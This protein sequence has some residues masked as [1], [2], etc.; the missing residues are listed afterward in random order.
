[1]TH[2]QD[3]R[4]ALA[5]ESLPAA[6]HDAS[7]AL[8]D[9]VQQAARDNT[10][11]RLVGGDSKG[12]Y[13]RPVSGE[14]LSL[15]E[16]TGIVH[17]D[18]VELVVTVRAGTRLTDLQQTLAEAGQ[19]LAFEPPHFADTATVGGMVACGIA[20]PRRPWAGSVRDF[21]LGTR[22]ITHDAKRLRFGG[23]VMKNVAGYDLSRLM[24]GAQ[25]T[26]GVIDEVSFKVLPRPAAS[27][28]LR[29]EMTRDAAMARL[30][31][32]GR[33]PL[34]I[35]G[36]AHDGETLHIRLEGGAGS[37]A[38]TRERLGGEPD[39]TDFWR[40]LRELKLDFF[41]RR[42][43]SRPLW[44]LSLPHRAPA[45]PLDGDE[46]VDWAGAQRWWRSH[47]SAET[48]RQHAA[49][50]GGHATRI[51]LDQPHGIEMPFTPLSPVL[52][53]YHR[54]LKAELDPHGI[55]NPGRLYEGL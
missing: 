42:N 45:V 54:R 40:R 50:V 41:S 15:A 27:A 24:V 4:P 17:Y 21:V 51:D 8:L 53:K 43:D 29:L 36:A 12:F 55:F 13:G 33:E 5:S 14:T 39:D 48:I 28:R 49:H 10:P 46:L 11:L 2:P 37:V 26:L 30:A 3:Q 19:Q 20:G 9:R 44:R 38:T 16:H 23:E 6:D 18:P 25:G 31:E 52:A 47:M 22:L 32:W 34:P 1:M 7:D 35:T